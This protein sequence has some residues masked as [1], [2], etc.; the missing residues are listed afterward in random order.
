M[1]L[2]L[3]FFPGVVLG[4]SHAIRAFT[5]PGDAIIIQPLVY[6]PFFSTVTANNRQLVLNPLIENNGQYVF[7]YDLL[8]K[9]VAQGATMLI[10]SNP[11]N[12]IGKL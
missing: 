6:R 12:P 7:D 4:L 8:E 9:Q 3:I 10:L 1:L 5:K 11:H 2:G